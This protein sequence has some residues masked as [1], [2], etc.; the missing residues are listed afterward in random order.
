[1]L[2]SNINKPLFDSAHEIFLAVTN[3]CFNIGI[4]QEFM[5][6]QEKYAVHNALFSVASS[7]ITG[8]LDNRT[9][10]YAINN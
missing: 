4:A 7:N 6:V 1:M 5:K 2:P 10:A 8:A 9:N 3:Y